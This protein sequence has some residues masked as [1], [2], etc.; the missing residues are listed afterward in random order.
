MTALH[1]PLLQ[2]CPDFFERAFENR[3]FARDA[4]AHVGVP[5]IGIGKR[6]AGRA[7]DAA[8]GGTFARFD[9]GRELLQQSAR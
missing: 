2:R 8:A 1:K 5:R 3:V 9:G 7:G 6:A 4:D